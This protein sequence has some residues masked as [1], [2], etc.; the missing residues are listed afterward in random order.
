VLLWLVAGALSSETCSDICR[1]CKPLGQDL[2]AEGEGP[3]YF[4][5]DSSITC[6]CQIT[7]DGS[8]IP[9]KKRAIQLAGSLVVRSIHKGGSSHLGK[10]FSKGMS[11]LGLDWTLL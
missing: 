9:L 11:K 5:E 3:Y 2:L 4:Y 6:N 7:D 10:S 8:G 1:A